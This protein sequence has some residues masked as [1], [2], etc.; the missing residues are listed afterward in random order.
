MQVDIVGA[1]A[2]PVPQQGTFRG[3]WPPGRKIHIHTYIHTGQN[4]TLSVKS[5]VLQPADAG[6]SRLSTA[7]R[8]VM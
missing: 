3:R 1:L 5:A 4:G 2:R 8:Y 7:V 6:Q